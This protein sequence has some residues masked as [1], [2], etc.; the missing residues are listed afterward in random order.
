MKVDSAGCTSKK[1][2]PQFKDYIVYFQNAFL[3]NQIMPLEKM[4]AR[5]RHKN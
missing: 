4:L 5:P 1:I 3:Y 2:T